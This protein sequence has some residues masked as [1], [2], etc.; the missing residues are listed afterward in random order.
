MM[1]L[2]KLLLGSAVLVFAN[3]AVA[4]TAGISTS[5]SATGATPA[6]AT[7]QGGGTVTAP[8]NSVI[9]MS[10]ASGSV[11]AGASGSTSADPI[12]QKRQAD[13]AANAEYKARKSTAKDEYK[14]DKAQAKSDLKAEKRESSQARKSGMAA[15]KKMGD[16]PA[17]GN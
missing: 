13:A 4:Q 7:I 3:F 14:E 8:G 16:T 2:P 9:P 6:G 17:I 1:K 11:G 5:T 10:P 15:D 12:V